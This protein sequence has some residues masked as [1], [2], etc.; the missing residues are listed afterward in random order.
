MVL[1]VRIT[2]GGTTQTIDLPIPLTAFTW[3]PVSSGCE[4]P[5]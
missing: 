3:K 5:L 4:R 1:R 2:A